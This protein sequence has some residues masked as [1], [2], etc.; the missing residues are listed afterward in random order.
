MK[1]LFAILAA[2]LF[3]TSVFLPQ[4]A[5]TQTHQKMS[6]QAVIR[7]SNNVL[8]TSTTVGMQISIL[9]GSATGTLVYSEIHT[10]TT[11]ANGLVTIEIGG[12]AGFDT[13]NWAIGSYFIKTETD[14]TGGTNYTITGSSQ[15]LS[16]PYALF[17]AGC[18]PQPGA[19]P[20]DMYFWN[21]SAWVLLPIGNQGQNLTV[22][23]GVPTWGPCPGLPTIITT[24]ATSISINTAMSGGNIT[25]DGGAAITA[26]GICWSTSSNPV[27]TGNH[28]T[29]SIGTGIFTSSITGLAAGTIYYV[30]AYATNSVGTAYGNEVI[31]TTASVLSIGLNYQGGIIAYILQV[32]DPG[33][34]SFVP[35]GFIAAPYD[36]SNSIKWYEGTLAIST[37]TVATALGTGN[38][39]TNDIVSVQGAGN[40]AA[41]LC[42]DLVLNGYSDWYLPSKDELF[43]LY[44]NRTLIGGFSNDCYWS[45]TEAGYYNAY[46]NSFNNGSYSTSGKSA[47]NSVRAIRSF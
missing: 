8:I 46:I 16:V 27:K 6:Y 11:N 19:N 2:V 45:S 5:S 37:G 18:T 22:C 17:S 40:Y 29:D 32:G 20:G 12:G 39:N 33:Y 43:K 4:Q 1:N 36:Q 23:N 34:N 44:L 28:T 26:R 21:G 30:R 24:S 14:P 10:P 9:Q 13:I 47:L 35:H 31:F 7:N 38:A 25:Y 41:K 3:S 42:F 15:L